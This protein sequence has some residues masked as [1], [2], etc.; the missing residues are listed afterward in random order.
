MIRISRVQGHDTDTSWAVYK[1]LDILRLIYL[2]Q[3]QQQPKSFVNILKVHWWVLNHG[4]IPGLLIY[5]WSVTLNLLQL[6]ISDGIVRI[7][8]VYFNNAPALL[9]LIEA[10]QHTTYIPTYLS[11]MLNIVF[12]VQRRSFFTDSKRFVPWGVNR[13]GVYSFLGKILTH[14]SRITSNYRKVNCPSPV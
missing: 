12:R 8:S 13:C 7:A 3:C 6:F 1:G 4:S 5:D 10:T 2:K 9:K 11:I 14:A